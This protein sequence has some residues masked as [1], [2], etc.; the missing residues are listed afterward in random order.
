[1]CVCVCVLRTSI[2]KMLDNGFKLTKER[3]RRY[4]AHTFTD[5]DNADDIAILVNTPTQ[6]ETLLHSLEQA[7]AGIGPNVN[8]YKT[9]YMSLNERGDIST[10]NVSSLKVVDRSTYQE[11]RVLSVETDIKSPLEKAWATIDRLSAIWKSHLT[12]K[13]KRSFSNQRS[14]LYCYMDALYGR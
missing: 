3:N 8:R 12:D 11:S 4:P 14:C 13:I 10:L 6:A 7:A 5:T 9:E 1:M 2:D